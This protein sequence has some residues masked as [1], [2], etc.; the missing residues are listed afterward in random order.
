MAIHK[1]IERANDIF[2]PDGWASSITY[3]AMDYE[4][5]IAITSGD[6]LLRPSSLQRQITEAN[7]TCIYDPYMQ[8]EANGKWETAA[9]AHV[10]VTL[11]NGS[12]HEDIGSGKGQNKYR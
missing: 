12:W 6:T 2:G 3:L 8:M 1:V 9:T 10:R 4:V 7:Y 5:R 11:A